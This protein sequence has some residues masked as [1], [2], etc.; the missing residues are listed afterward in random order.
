MI[1]TCEM[2]ERKFMK[3]QKKFFSFK[4]ICI[5]ALILAVFVVLIFIVVNKSKNE[6]S[7]DISQTTEDIVET[8][9]T[10][11]NMNV[12]SGYQITTETYKVVDEDLDYNIIIEYPSISGIDNE[13]LENIINTRL[14]LKAF[15]DLLDCTN[16]QNAKFHVT[17]DIEYVLGDFISVK[18]TS[19]YFHKA[20]AY[21]H[22]EIY[23]LNMMLNEDHLVSLDDLIKIDEEFVNNFFENFELQNSNG[24]YD[25]WTVNSFNKDTKK[26]DLS[27]EIWDVGQYF[28]DKWY[29]SD[30]KIVLIFSNA[31]GGMDHIFYKSK[32]ID[33]DELINNL[34]IEH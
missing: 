28:Q 23:T 1:I 27:G 29:I 8:P 10:D 7:E 13:S 25:E 4:S 26:Y 32:N 18:Y 3:S 31:G 14:E 19:E 16:L 11:I 15:T 24:V 6:Q 22:I 2:K 9:S 17:Y 20:M 5:F 34:N 33:A 21:P 12:E 30:N